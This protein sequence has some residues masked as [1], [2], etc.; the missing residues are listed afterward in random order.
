MTPRRTAEERIAERSAKAPAKRLWGWAQARFGSRVLASAGFVD[1]LL[2]RSDLSRT[3]TRLMQGAATIASPPFTDG[4]SRRDP[5]IADCGR[6]CRIWAD[7]GP[8]R[9]ASG[10]TGVPFLPY[11][12]RFEVT[13]CVPP[14]APVAL[15][16]GGGING[17]RLAQCAQALGVGFA[18]LFS[19]GDNSA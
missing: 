5:D 4:R 12:S 2:S 16:R 19:R 17:S 10:R 8:T 14:C 11:R 3:Q 15:L 6:G 13:P 9:I 18:S 7:R 1:W